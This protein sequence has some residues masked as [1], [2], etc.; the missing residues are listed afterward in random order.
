MPFTT[1]Q[2][3]QRIATPSLDQWAASTPQN[4]DPF[5]PDFTAYFT[6]LQDWITQN[7]G[8]NPF[9]WRDIT[10]L[11]HTNGTQVV[12]PGPAQRAPF[13]DAFDD[14][15]AHLD[16]PGF[17]LYQGAEALRRLVGVLNMLR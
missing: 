12:L 3:A 5:L 7:G 16:G 10:G 11:T 15:R 14:V 17:R 6:G 8:A 4:Q 9:G 1:A 2:L 13:N